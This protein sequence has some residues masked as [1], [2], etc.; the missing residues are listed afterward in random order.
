[1]AELTYAINTERQLVHVDSVPNG[2]ACKCICPCCGAALVAKNNGETV[3]PHFAHASGA[4]C[5]GALESEL[6]LLAKDI[7]A[8]DKCV[9]LPPYGN[10]YRGGVVIFDEVEIEKRND[11]SSLQPDLCGVV[12]AGYG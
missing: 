3:V 9:M 7:I 10:V 4:S 12:V 2:I 8:K 11:I 1:M 6:H 5:N